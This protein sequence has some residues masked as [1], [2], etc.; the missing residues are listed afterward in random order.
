MS[1]PFRPQSNQQ[2][3]R[4]ARIGLTLL[5]ITLIVFSYVC[6]QR[7]AGSGIQIPDHVLN[8]PIAN[9]VWPG[10]DPTMLAKG[11]QPP[12]NTSLSFGSMISGAR[13]AFGM[14]F[15]Q[16]RK[17]KPGAKL[18]L[19]RQDFEDPVAKQ[20]LEAFEPPIPE[21]V[22]PVNF[23]VEIKPKT[24]A[25]QALHAYRESRD[26]LNA[27]PLD[28]NGLRQTDRADTKMVSSSKPEKYEIKP[29]PR[30][31][32]RDIA[33]QRGQSSAIKL[34]T[35]EPSGGDSE[36]GEFVVPKRS[37]EKVSTDIARSPAGSDFP[38]RSRN[39]DEQVNVRTAA[40]ESEPARL[41]ERPS[42]LVQPLTPTEPTSLAAET[43]VSLASETPILPKSAGADS[44]GSSQR[45]TV[46]AGDSFWSIS[47]QAYDD[48]RFYS[49]LFEYNR[50]T[51]GSF[52]NLSPGMV[53]ATPPREEL[54]RMW[55]KLCPKIASTSLTAK[56][57]ETR[58][59]VTNQGDTLFDIARQKLGQ[60]SRYLEIMEA[61]SLRLEANTTH[62]TPLASGIKLTLP[63]N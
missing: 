38:T 35:P 49:A 55:P 7:I 43:E 2:L 29:N 37:L 54:I 25:R 3:L 12:A 45:Y 9:S 61:N 31:P 26:E 28:V 8:A 42:R 27:L 19:P 1:D 24:S 63:K 20:E 5:A 51:V 57:L 44:A 4:E 41:T 23:E 21:R 33:T 16:Q 58:F 13:K 46:L 47:Q 59:Y 30:L 11:T 22:A 18:I 40:F 48:G 32:K 53:I 15:N 14:N 50:Q 52:E 34:E 6:Y 39:S 10:E 62:L 60:A 17:S 56:Q 36:I